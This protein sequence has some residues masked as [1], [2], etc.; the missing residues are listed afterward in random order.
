M[1]GET[2]MFKRILVAVDGSATSNAGLRAAVALAADQRSTLAVVHVIDLTPP[3]VGPEAAFYLPSYIDDYEAA[4]VK[5]GRKLL[6]KAVALA[7]AAGVR[8][9]PRLART[10]AGTVAAAV[11]GEARKAKADVIVLGTHGRRGLRR[12]VMGSDA[13]AIVRQSRVPVLLVRG[14]RALRTPS[15]APKRAA[16]RRRR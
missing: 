12:V 8:A 10:R 1:I 11:L 13:E 4:L 3:V 6:D 7:R 16:K 2:A 5:G 9:E 14:A 15:A